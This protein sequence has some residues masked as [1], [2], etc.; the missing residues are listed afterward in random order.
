MNQTII[1]GVLAL[2]FLFAIFRKLSKLALLVLVGA[3]V[4]WYYTR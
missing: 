4:Y 3:A 1:I 2:L